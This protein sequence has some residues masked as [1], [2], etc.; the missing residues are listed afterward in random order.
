MSDDLF[1]NPEQDGDD[2]FLNTSGDFA[3]NIGAPPENPVEA[4]RAPNR[5]KAIIMIGAGVAVVGFFL[6]RGGSGSSGG[7]Q[8]TANPD[9]EFAPPPAVVQNP[10]D[11][12][13]ID[14]AP[15]MGG[16]SDPQILFD[17]P[18]GMAPGDDPLGMAGAIATLPIGGGLPPGSP[19]LP[20]PQPA[21]S[22]T[23]W[24]DEGEFRVTQAEL[25][26]QAVLDARREAEELRLARA[27]AVRRERTEREALL[28]ELGTVVAAGDIPINAP[29][30][31]A[32]RFGGSP[33]LA[34]G[35]EGG[36]PATTANTYDLL[37]GTK[38]SAVLMSDYRSN[39]SGGR[40]EARL[41]QPL[42]SRTGAVIL[43]AGTRAFG[44]A[45]AENGRPGSPATV[46]IRFDIFVTPQNQ[47]IR[48]LAGSA[49]DART[50]AM[51]IAAMTDN[52]YVERVLRGATSTA[53]GLA[54]T[55]N[56]QRTSV[57]EQPSQR[58]M[59]IADAR[60]RAEA[61][62]SGPIGDEGSVGPSVRL[63]RDTPF[64]IIFG[65]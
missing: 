47:V 58:D 41:T 51:S 12:L 26:R 56:T 55:Q 22:V 43:P 10:A 37:P 65:F 30:T 3:D 23:S 28:R 18:P 48:D 34:A 1:N 32:S 38:I 61:I 25:D 36:T 2:P 21:Q 46:A 50:G 19:P 5:R 6:L 52:H 11:I 16:A 35:L 60:A 24:S 14:P 15:F 27:E 44:T 53:V 57:F 20:Q 4:A 42:R 62:I 63:E 31:G 8:A 29:N 59:V 64:V 54:L 33:A 13:S 49:G 9:T 7:P 17:S 39:L 45:S 40:V